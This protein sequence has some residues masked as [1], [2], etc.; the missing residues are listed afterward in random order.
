MSLPYLATM[1]PG[2]ESEVVFFI[3]PAGHQAL[4]SASGRV[5]SMLE[6]GQEPKLDSQIDDARCC[7][8]GGLS[9]VGSVA[10]VEVAGPVIAS[11]SRCQ[12]EMW[13]CT[14]QDALAHTLRRVRDDANVKGVALKLDCPGGSAP[15]SEELIGLVAEIAAKKPMAAVVGTCATSLAAFLSAACREVVASQNAVIGSIGEVMNLVDSSKAF[16]MAGL[17][18]HAVTEQRLKPVGAPGVPITQEMIDNIAALVRDQI[19]P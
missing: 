6:R 4:L 9:L 8:R 11:M 19:E 14:S 12:A 5:A 17:K 7:G 2:L 16:E 15:G 18:A 10:V 3:T 13:G 1:I